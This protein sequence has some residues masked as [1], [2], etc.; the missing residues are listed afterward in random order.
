MKI[1]VLV[2]YFNFY[3][4]KYLEGINNQKQQFDKV[5][6]EQ[7]CEENN[8]GVIE[9]QKEN[10][11]ER[12]IHEY[13]EKNKEFDELVNKEIPHHEENKEPDESIH[14]DEKKVE[15]VYKEE[16]CNEEAV[17]ASELMEQERNIHKNTPHEKNNESDKLVEESEKPNEF[18]KTEIHQEEIVMEEPM[19][20]VQKEGGQNKE[21]GE[22]KENTK[23]S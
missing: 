13:S 23:K 20:I 3:N 12:I 16:E 17:K 15:T 21:M 19:E 2:N 9:L 14:K 8:K 6:N 11:Q 1:K 10:P 4:I 22:R 5:N 7:E 18:K